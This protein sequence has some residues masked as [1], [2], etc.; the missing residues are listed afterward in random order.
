MEINIHFLNSS[1]RYIVVILLESVGKTPSSTVKP[2]YTIGTM[3]KVF[4]YPI[5]QRSWKPV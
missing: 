4:V 3:Q 2:P 5:N 1:T